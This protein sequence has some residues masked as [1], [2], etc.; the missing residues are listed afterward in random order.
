MAV[1]ADMLAD[2]PLFAL[3]D[4]EERRTLAQILDTRRVVRG[5]VIFA[6]GDPGDA[7]C[8][9][10][11]GK[12]ELSIED[13]EGLKIVLADA[14]PGDLFGELSLLDGGP[15]TATALAVEDSELLTIDRGDLHEVI[16]RHPHAAIDLMTV[17]GRRL[18]ATDELLRTRVTRN[19]NEEHADRLTF[20]ERIADQVASFGGSWTF[21]LTFGAVLVLWMTANAVFL[22][23]RPFDPYPFILLNLVLSALAS[24][25]APVIMMSQNRQAAKDRL[26]AD[27]DYQVDLKAELEVAQLHRK[28]DRLQEALQA[29]L[30]KS[31][32]ADSTTLG[33]VDT[34]WRPTGTDQET[35]PASP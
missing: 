2:V 1:D 4:D 32:R 33:L 22:A 34:E 23:S 27:L 3:L 29:H 12:V 13:D 16:R 20:G 14:G 25:Q 21:I 6:S 35:R 7:L 26:K 24:I 28:V 9:V 30:A 18:R 10:L 8:L 31:Q 15:R 17:M 5:E 11:A 19:V